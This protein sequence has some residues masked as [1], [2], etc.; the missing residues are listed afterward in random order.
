MTLPWGTGS[1]AHATSAE[2]RGTYMHSSW[3][4][5][6]FKINSDL[7]VGLR[8]PIHQQERCIMIQIM[9]EQYL[10]RNGHMARP[11]DNKSF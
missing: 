3:P 1:A 10:H 4:F 2:S 6:M 8:S 9:S 11:V 7:S 5:C